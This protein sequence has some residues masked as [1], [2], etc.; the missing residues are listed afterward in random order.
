MF[1]LLLIFSSFATVFGQSNEVLLKQA[2]AAIEKK[3]YDAALRD[4]NIILAEKPKNADALAQRARVFYFQKKLDEAQAD[5][6]KVIG[7]KSRNSAIAWNISGLIQSDKKDYKAAIELFT[8]SIDSDPTFAR[9]FYNRAVARQKDAEAKKDNSALA[10]VLADYDAFIKVEPKNLNAVSEAGFFCLDMLGEAA[11]CA[12]YFQTLKTLAP[13]SWVSY[14]GYAYAYAN[15]FKT[16]A[17]KEFLKGEIVQNYRRAMELEPKNFKIPEQL[18]RLQFDLGLYDESIDSLTQSL[19]LKPDND[20][21][22]SMRGDVYHYKKDYDKAIADYTKAIEL[23]PKISLTYK[24]RA[25][26]LREK[27]IAGQIGFETEHDKAFWQTIAAD[28]RKASELGAQT[29]KSQSEL[30]LFLAS[31]PPSSPKPWMNNQKDEKLG[32]EL[33]AAVVKKDTKTALEL[34]E[35]NAK[36]NYLGGE[37]QTSTIY[38]AAAMKDLTLVRALLE[39]GADPNLNYPLYKAVSS[40]D[41]AMVELLIKYKANVNG[42]YNENKTTFLMAAATFAEDEN[43]VR[44]LLEAGADK[45]AIDKDGGTALA[46]AERYGKVKMAILLGGSAESTAAGVAQR[47]TEQA[48][49]EESKRLVANARVNQAVAEYNRVHA[50]VEDRIKTYAVKREKLANAGEAAYLYKGTQAEAQRALR[51]SVLAIENLMTTHGKYLPQDLYDHIVE[52]YRLVGGV[53]NY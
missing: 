1:C 19:A 37:Y 52:D 3:D 27:G 34:I 31:I 24:L 6:N 23:D 11:T 32:K 39:A 28:Y 40:N 16:V 45:S 15:N 44:L 4:L 49:R 10:T 25:R 33:Y 22:F 5:V 2:M 7:T 14:F 41:A 38:E 29:A 30:E 53:K 21:A 18:G 8:R 42:T 47:K 36:L 51:L 20:W 35:R 12:K 50:E 17:D 48:N 46:N 43:I 13:G 26:T 9:A